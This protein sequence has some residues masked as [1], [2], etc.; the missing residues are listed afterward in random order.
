MN[1]TDKERFRRRL[2]EDQQLMWMQMVENNNQCEEH[3]N[4][5]ENMNITVQE[6]NL[7]FAQQDLLNT[8]DEMHRFTHE[9]HRELD[10]WS[11]GANNRFNSMNNFH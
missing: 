9:E 3:R 6:N 11:D 8:V 5:T 7:N 10:M 4:F 1:N 2:I